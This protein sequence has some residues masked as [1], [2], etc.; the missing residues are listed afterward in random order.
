MSSRPQDEQYVHVMKRRPGDISQER[1]HELQDEDRKIRASTFGTRSSGRRTL[2]R[3]LHS[4]EPENHSLHFGQAET[5]RSNGWMLRL[6]VGLAALLAFGAVLERAGVLDESPPFRQ[7][8]PT[9]DSSCESNAFGG[10]DGRIDLQRDALTAS[11]VQLAREHDLAVLWT[12]EIGGVSQQLRQRWVFT[13]DGPLVG[14][15]L[16][17]SSVQRNVVFGCRATVAVIDDGAWNAFLTGR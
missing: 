3:P 17:E 5:G 16:P 8:V 4:Q 2:R 14:A 11:L 13:E 7:A 9:I 1:A 15:I 6:F 10:L 12:V